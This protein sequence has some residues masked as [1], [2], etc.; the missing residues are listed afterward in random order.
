MN[1][2]IKTG[3]GSNF[4]SACVILQRLGKTVVKTLDP[5]SRGVAAGVEVVGSAATDNVE[6]A[7]TEV[8]RCE[9]C[10]SWR[11]AWQEGDFRKL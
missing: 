1:G 8:Y 5:I 6:R 9:S 2:F 7:R 3:P 10:S 11:T 4:T